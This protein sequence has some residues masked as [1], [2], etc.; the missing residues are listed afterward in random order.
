MCIYLE[1][2]RR[3]FAEEAEFF[4]LHFL[5]NWG[6]PC[7]ELENVLYCFITVACP[8]AETSSQMLLFSQSFYCHG[9]SFLVA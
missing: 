1:N 2:E 8:T 7:S 6:F 5:D 9:D 3:I 4:S